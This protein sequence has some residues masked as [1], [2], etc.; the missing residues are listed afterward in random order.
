MS[1]VLVVESGDRRRMYPELFRELVRAGVEPVLVSIGPEGTGQ[2]QARKAGIPTHALGCTSAWHYAAASRR[3]AK[4][5]RWHDARIIHAIETI[6][7]TVAGLAALGR[8]G[9]RALFHRQHTVTPEL[10]ALTGMSRVASRLCSATI[11]CSAATAEAAVRVDHVAVDRIHVVHNAAASPR[12]VEPAEVEGL[13]RDLGISEG[14][15]VIATIARLRQEKNLAR[16]IA[17]ASAAADW[18]PMEVHLVIVGDGPVRP[19]LERAAAGH[20]GVTT[21]LVGEHWEVG[22]WLRMA[23]VFAIPSLREPFG[24]AAAEAMSYSLPVVAADVDGLRE[25]VVGADTGLLVDPEDVPG[26]ARVLVAV[27]ADPQLA[28]AMGA[29]GERR[30]RER[31]TIRRWAEQ[32]AE[33]YSQV[34]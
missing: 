27:L 33:V 17:A 34:T 4:L 25:V 23:T 12:K 9:L 32:W 21:H 7:A 28:A 5:A 6:P 1:V 18:L 20:P 10:R 30:Y 31:F 19:N 15:A 8:P 11:A 2:V 3:L 13:R 24:I 16:L 29:A 26:I 22:P 14:A